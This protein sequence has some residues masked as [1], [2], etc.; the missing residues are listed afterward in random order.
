MKII[1]IVLCVVAAVL[2]GVIFVESA[3]QTKDVASTKEGSALLPLDENENPC[4]EKNGPFAAYRPFRFQFQGDPEYLQCA[5]ALPNDLIRFLT[6]LISFGVLV[7][8]GVSLWKENKWVNLVFTIL[9]GLIS[10]SY[11][12]CLI[13]DANDVRKSQDWCETR[14]PGVTK[15]NIR[16]GKSGGSITDGICLYTQFILMCCLDV[17]ACI[18]W[19]ILTGAM[20]RYIRHYLFSKKTQSAEES[21][22]TQKESLLGS[23]GGFYT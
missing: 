13:L 5:W 6:S 21:D 4:T 22:P 1:L 7:L 16:N 10:C 23:D 12:G 8:G 9:V 15:E 14:M 2:S 17:L 20:V 18:I 3:L 19:I 11:F